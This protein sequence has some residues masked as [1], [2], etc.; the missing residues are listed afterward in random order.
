MGI[1]SSSEIID[2]GKSKKPSFIELSLANIMDY[3]NISTPYTGR[4]RSNLSL[5]NNGGLQS[6]WEQ[7]TN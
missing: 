2:Y 7:R 5:I 6:V 1:D 4:I 3:F